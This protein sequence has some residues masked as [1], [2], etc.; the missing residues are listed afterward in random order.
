VFRQFG[1]AASFLG[2]LGL[3]ALVLS[4]LAGPEDRT[5]EAA[6]AVESR[7]VAF[8]GGSVHTLVAGP[9]LGRPV[10]LLHGAMFQSSTWQNTGTLPRLAQEGFRVFAVDL[11]GHG[12]SPEG[13]L[14]PEAVLSALIPALELSRPVVVAPSMSGRY[15]FPL[16]VAE[17]QAFS[18]IVL[19]A[20]A[21]IRTYRAVVEKV[22]LPVLMVWGEKDETV[23][24]A[25]SYLLTT[26]WPQAERLVLEGAG[27]AAYLDRPEAFNTALVEFLR[28]LP[29][30]GALT[31]PGAAS[32]SPPADGAETARPR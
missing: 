10:L 19:V 8:L 9:A 6:P 20:P 11:P 7:E 26:R 32:G 5:P 27:H 4:C 12:L 3:A 18:G 25:E 17:P 23:P 1:F 22:Q 16:L 28:G 29:A 30:A 2:V 13:S 14:P 21:G 24:V 15:V 31:E